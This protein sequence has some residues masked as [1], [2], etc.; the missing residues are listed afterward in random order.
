MKNLLFALLAL[1]ASQVV[2]G[3]ASNPAFLKQAIQNCITRC[4]ASGFS[5]CTEYGCYC[6]TTCNH[7]PF[8]SFNS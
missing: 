6:D 2:A 4:N 5:G 7:N 8:Q 3:N 1:G